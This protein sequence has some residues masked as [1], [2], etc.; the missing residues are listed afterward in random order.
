[1]RVASWLLAATLLSL[2]TPLFADGPVDLDR[3]VLG[4]FAGGRKLGTE[5]FLIQTA[6][7]S[8]SVYASVLLM[9]PGP[10][11]E[12]SLAKIVTM[13]LSDFDYDLHHYDSRQRFRGDML[14]RGV[15]PRD[16][17]YTVFRELNG[18]GLGVAYTR[19]PGR[20]FVLDGQIFT[21]FVLICRHLQG[22]DFEKRPLWLL[23]LSA[24]DTL[25]Q[26][27]VKNL[28]PDTLRWGGRRVVARKLSVSDSGLIC[29]LWATAD[30]RM[31]Q[32]EQPEAGIRVLREPPPTKPARKRK[33]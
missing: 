7:D 26:V 24:R 11:G 32:L 17:L 33:A 16:T 15:E 12:D 4:V 8:L 18:H 23:A 10:Q 28:G 19:P 20:L 29:L 5:E 9:L 31:I 6:G 25:L 21:S 3:G 13:R 1:M 30:G 27:E 14:V 2:P 22:R